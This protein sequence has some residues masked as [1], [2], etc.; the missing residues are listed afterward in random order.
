MIIEKLKLLGAY[1]AH[2]TWRYDEVRCR[3]TAASLSFTSLL[4]IVPMVA[5]FLQC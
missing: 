4:A 1:M 3:S 2:I 5:I